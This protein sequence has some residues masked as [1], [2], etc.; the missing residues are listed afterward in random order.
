MKVKA[1]IIFHLLLLFIGKK[2]YAQEL[3]LDSL[4]ILSNEVSDLNKKAS[5]LNQ[6]G[7]ELRY[8]DYEKALLYVKESE[9][10]SKELKN[11]LQLAESYII[12]GII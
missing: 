6:I 4:I 9:K 10:L 8:T 1:L 5:I 12:Q 7:S 2:L 3:N 11:K